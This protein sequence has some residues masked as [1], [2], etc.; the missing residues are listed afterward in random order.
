MKMTQLPNEGYNFPQDKSEEEQFNF[1]TELIDEIEDAIYNELIFKIDVTINNTWMVEIYEHADEDDEES[2]D[3]LE[4][5]DWF[6]GSS[7]K[8]IF[9]KLMEKYV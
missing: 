6:K 3:N 9:D 2:F 8:D 7:L 4:L 1:I 5:V